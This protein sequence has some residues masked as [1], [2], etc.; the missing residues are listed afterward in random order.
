MTNSLF[1]FGQAFTW[2]GQS[3]GDLLGAALVQVTYQSCLISVVDMM[4]ISGGQRC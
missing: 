4:L 3:E 2:L 1:E